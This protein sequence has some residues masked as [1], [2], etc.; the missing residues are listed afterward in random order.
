MTLVYI[1]PII[2]LIL[3]AVT[4]VYSP[5]IEKFVREQ[6]QES[7]PDGYPSTLVDP[8]IESDGGFAG[9]EV[10]VVY[11]EEDGIGEEVQLNIKETLAELEE[12]P[13]DLPLN[14]V[15]TPFD[16]EEEEQ[17]LSDDEDVLLAMLELEVDSADFQFIRDDINEKTEA[18]GVDH[19]LTG[20]V[21]IDEDVN[22]ST[23]QGLETSTYIT[24]ILVFTVLAI[25]FRSPVAP[26]VPLLLLGS[27][28]V[29]SIGAV[30]YL[31]GNA[32]FPVSNFT[33]I[34]VL[35][36]VFGVGTD[37]CILVMKRFQAELSAGDGK[38][39]A[40]KRT[41]SGS[42]KT[43]L[44]SA[45]TG[46][47]GFSAIGLA[48]FELYRSAVGVAIGMIFLMIG[49]WAVM[50]AVLAL[51][52]GLMFW[53][54]KVTSVAVD[55]RFW[56]ALGRFSIFRPKTALLVV[57]LIMIPLLF[58]Y[59]NARSFDSIEEIQGDFE[60]V[61]AYDYID[62]AFGEGEM[63][64]A[65]VVLQSDDSWKKSEH[66]PYL[67]Q[68]AK[69]IA[70]LD[71]VD[72]ARTVSRPL[73]ETQ[74]EFTVPYQAAELSDGLSEAIDG[75]EELE[76]G[77]EEMQEEVEN[78]EED[79]DEAEEGINELIAGTDEALEGVREIRSGLNE[80]AAELAEAEAEVRE[81]EDQIDAYRAEVAAAEEDVEE[82]EEDIAEARSRAE[83]AAADAEERIDEI[84]REA[85]SFQN[86]AEAIITDAEE[87]LDRARELIDV[88][89][90]PLEELAELDID[91]DLDFADADSFF[92]NLE[93][94]LSEVEEQLNQSLDQMEEVLTGLDVED[95]Q[96]DVRERLRDEW[97]ERDLFENG[98]ELDIEEI[99]AGISEE[100]GVDG[101]ELRG[102]VLSYLD[103]VD[104]FL[105]ALPEI[106]PD[107][108][109]EEFDDRIDEAK[110][111]V[112]E[113]RG[114]VADLEE[115]EWQEE[116]EAVFA[117]L[118]LVD[119]TVNQ[120]E[121]AVREYLFTEIEDFIG[122]FEDEFSRAEEELTEISERLPDLGR[123]EIDA[124]FAE[125]YDRL[126]E[127]ESTLLA[128]AD[129]FPD[130]SPREFAA[131]LEQAIDDMNRIEADVRALVSD[132]EE[133]YGQLEDDF[134]GLELED[135]LESFF[136][137]GDLPDPDQLF[138]TIYSE[139]DRAEDDLN[140]LADGLAEAVSALNEAVDGLNELE[141]GLL[142]IQEGHLELLEGLQMVRE[143]ADE[144]TTGLQ[145]ARDG[146]DEISEG[147]ED[148][149]ELLD[150]IADQP[151]NPLEGFFVP[152]EAMDEEDFQ[153]AWDMY[154]TPD[155]HNVALIEATLE[156][157]PYSHEAMDLLY[158]M[159]Y[160][161]EFSLNDTP[162]E[163]ADMA[164]DGI[165]SDNRDLRDVSTSD[166]IRTAAIMLIGIFTALV[167]QFRSLVMPLVVLI[168][169][170]AAYFGAVS[171]T[172]YVFTTFFGADGLMWAVPFFGF[173]LLTALGV[174]YSI[175]LLG[176]MTEVYKGGGTDEISVQQNA[177]A[178]QRALLFSMKRVG[179]TVLS[180]AF[181]L[182]GTFASMI[183]S[184]VLT[185]L[186]ISILTITGL[187]FYTLVILPLFVPASIALLGRLSW[188]PLMKGRE[189]E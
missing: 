145:E 17:L 167:V 106:V 30:S 168:S 74:E 72:S 79:I 174:D 114:R 39:S 69:N 51:M 43:V 107:E 140:E 135:E 25:I 2:W 70:K 75:L 187:L 7:P 26:I 188:W 179:G 157:D 183:P 48:D 11:R 170:V 60:S 129:D 13:G 108:L 45:F 28:Y 189:K 96:E 133:A 100:S 16:G 3:A 109:A 176:R 61:E 136:P 63:F 103:E 78:S 184:G 67:E 42:R 71:G 52:G 178:I 171:I 95:W 59:E 54:A 9:E 18:D 90:L 153:D 113:V 83:E 156:Y 80:L 152:E 65:T 141:T 172:E 119:E 165:M 15:I 148:A 151:A 55:N 50:P 68:T 33:Q 132:V 29:S 31:I 27:V 102:A 84:Q 21:V 35:T 112:D 85:E 128:V 87:S 4:Y 124:V 146:A 1:I 121:E 185:L 88:E 94:R 73:G 24:V 131:A 118:E 99:L 6:G 139:L 160:I 111:A 47:I 110:G 150:E 105:A 101:E 147:L 22:V 98:A 56:G 38:E 125:I 12:S 82:I 77:L 5:D 115:E 89:D 117:E 186:Q 169:L 137:D 144:L 155:E 130:V 104:A 46:W 120:L 49:L 14:D 53:P 123:D 62:D 23:E 163:E 134:A 180:A 10:I 37:Y 92:D 181:I 159:E 142:E 182:G 19:Y 173:A 91:A 44:Y 97:K 164:I 122:G 86:R 36:V 93:A 76:S 41:M 58:F 20:A 66:A 143:A 116:L 138:Q 175:F 34:F 162:F 40:M 149:R 126:D 8:M 64:F 81:A 57:V 154:V 161:T 127:V 158:E 177:T 32:G 166:F